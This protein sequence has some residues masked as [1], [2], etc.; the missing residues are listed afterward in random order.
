VPQ[1]F[2]TLDIVSGE[3][4]G[5]EPVEEVTSIFILR[6]PQSGMRSQSGVFSVFSVS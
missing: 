2:Q 4:L 6:V 3:T 5:F 1:T